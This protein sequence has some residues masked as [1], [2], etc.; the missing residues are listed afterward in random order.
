MLAARAIGL[1][2]VM[3]A[4]AAG[5]Q[6]RPRGD[7]ASPPSPSPPCVPAGIADVALG[8]PAAV[9]EI[10]VVVAEGSP[11]GGAA[12]VVVEGGRGDRVLHI[13]GGSH[14]LQFFPALRGTD[15]R[16]SLS[17]VFGAASDACVER[18][19]LRRGGAPV[20]TVAF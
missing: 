12:E 2:V 17:P 7:E 20:A 18:V 14:A 1:A 11:E 4:A 8:A 19:E 5:A 13:R 16:V 15:L 6:P 9:D 3:A 10:R